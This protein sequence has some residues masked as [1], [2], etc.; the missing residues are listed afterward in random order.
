MGFNGCDTP[1]MFRRTTFTGWFSALAANRGSARF[2]RIVVATGMLVGVFLLLDR[3]RV[4]TLLSAADPV[5]LLLAILIV[6]IQVV[7][8]ALRWRSIAGRLGFDIAP[9]LAIREYYF[10]ALLNQFLPGGVI[11]D[12]AR[13][14]RMVARR[15]REAWSD[16]AAEQIVAAVILDRAAGQATMTVVLVIGLLLW[17]TL[18]SISA[19]TQIWVLLGI[20]L[21]VLIMLTFLVRFV[22]R[23]L[24]ERLQSLLSVLG[25]G[26]REGVR[27]PVF[28]AVQVCFNLAV[29][30]SYIAG[31]AL[32]GAAI[33]APLPPIALMTVVP[34]ALFSMAVPVS[35][36][37][38]GL[39]E[40]AA[41]L[42][43][44]LVGLS[45]SEGF[46][47]AFA[48]G[49]VIS[50]GAIPGIY[51]ALTRPRM[52]PEKPDTVNNE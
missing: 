48:Y 4:V 42:L 6:P 28:I 44:P 3:A 26:I 27:Y 15:N 41:A 18:P 23:L 24:P 40:G 5:L 38:W 30:A 10:G 31:F 52:R 39:R 21:L 25:D 11:G 36:G 32:A 14:W 43:W 8:S 19:P 7:L 35:I 20:L 22:A 45:A 29:I 47:T 17:P 12:V 2:L 46:A 51:G 49:L 50:L 1:V 34:V 13:G 9:L 37:G 16:V 33:G